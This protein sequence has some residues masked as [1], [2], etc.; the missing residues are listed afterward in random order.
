MKILLVSDS[1]RFLDHLPRVVRKYKGNVDLMI[2]CG[3][4]ALPSNDPVMELFDIAVQ[5]NHDDDSYPEVVVYGDIL[6]THGHLY[7]V[8]D[9]YD[10]LITLCKENRCTLCFHGHTHVPVIRNL[11]GITF[12]NP[13]SLMANRGTYPFGTYAIVNIFNDIQVA[14]YRSDND[15]MC[16]DSILQDGLRQLEEFRRLI[17]KYQLK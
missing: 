5:G 7:N 3:D 16:Q 11:Q 8:Y 12:V 13:G 6:V 9:G 4:S 2:H 15:V 10:E 14:F 17:K 1:H